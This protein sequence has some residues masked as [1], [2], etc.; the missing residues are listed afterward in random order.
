MIVHAVVEF[1][2]KTNSDRM[3]QLLSYLKQ[4]PRRRQIVSTLHSNDK[5]VP[6][7]HQRIRKDMEI[8]SAAV[9]KEAWDRRK[10]PNNRCAGSYFSSNITFDASMIRVR[11][12]PGCY[13]GYNISAM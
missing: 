3:F 12:F 6:R 9:T 10:S 1:E 4:Y 5:T 2:N 8:L 11:R 7:V 13:C